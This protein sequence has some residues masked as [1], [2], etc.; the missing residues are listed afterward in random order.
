[1]NHRAG[2]GAAGDHRISAAE[3]AAGACAAGLP[4]QRQLGARPAAPVATDPPVTTVVV[5]TIRRPQT[6][7]KRHGLVRGGRD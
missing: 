4:A 6:T 5:P 7:L 1:V 3:P 2:S